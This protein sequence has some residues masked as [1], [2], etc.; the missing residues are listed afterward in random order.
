M[1]GRQHDRQA[2]MGQQTLAAALATLPAQIAGAGDTMA[3]TTIR[4]DF[5]ARHAITVPFDGAAHHP[6]FDAW[7]ALLATEA[8]LAGR[9]LNP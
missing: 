6:L 7:T 9:P 5:L 8:L 4:R 1:T 3:A 2:A